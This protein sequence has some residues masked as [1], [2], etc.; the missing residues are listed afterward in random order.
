V[1]DGVEVCLFENE[2]GK[3]RGSLFAMFALLQS[4]ASLWRQLGYGAKKGNAPVTNDTA[5]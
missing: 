5:Y 4:F 3:R 1:S 2:C